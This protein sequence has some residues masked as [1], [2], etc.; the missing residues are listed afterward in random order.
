M[1]PLLT[2]V[3]ALLS[4]SIHAQTISPEQIS[5]QA[6]A[7]TGS[8]FK[9]FVS[10]ATLRIDFEKLIAAIE[11]FNHYKDWYV[12]CLESTILQINP[13]STGYT[14]F[15]NDLPWPYDNRD[16]VNEFK[17]T[18]TS[19]SYFMS[20]KSRADHIP[21]KEDLYRITQSEGS[22]KLSKLKSG[23]VTIQYTLYVNPGDNIPGSFANSTMENSTKESLF[24][25]LQRVLTN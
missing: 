7:V 19:D 10:Q 5:I 23:E 3:I 11:D 4:L 8:K 2:L 21:K 25:L 9:R 1:K 24:R 12:D 18:R 15:V 6:E 16:L 20:F 17:L 13:D 14:Y 22:W